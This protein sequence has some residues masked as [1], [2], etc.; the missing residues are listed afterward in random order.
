MGAVDG[1]AQD[2]DQAGVRKKFVNP[3]RRLRVRHIL[4]R[5]I[6]DDLLRMDVCKVLQIPRHSLPESAFVGKEADFLHERDV[7]PWMRPEVMKQGSGARLL[8]ANDDE[9][10]LARD[11]HALVSMVCQTRRSPI[12]KPS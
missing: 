11:G 2:R 7:N 1:V 9:V 4:R 8:C 12:P 6:P 3:C 10:D 5:D